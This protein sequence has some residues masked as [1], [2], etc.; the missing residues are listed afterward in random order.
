MTLAAS[1]VSIP[2]LVGRN[3]RTA[4]TPAEKMTESMVTPGRA[5]ISDAALRREVLSHMSPNINVILML[6]SIDLI[7]LITGSCLSLLRPTKMNCL[8]PAAAREMAAS[9]PSE[10]LLAPVMRTG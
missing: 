5:L 4:M 1:W 8:G 6:E 2:S 9:A 3:S 7:A 10:S